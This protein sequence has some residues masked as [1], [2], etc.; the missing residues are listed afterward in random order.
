MSRSGESQTRRRQQ[1]CFKRP[2]LSFVAVTG[3]L[4]WITPQ[5]VSAADAA[6][7]PAYRY[8]RVATAGRPAPGGGTFAAYFEPHVVINKGNDVAF[9][10]DTTDG[11]EGVYLR[12]LGRVLKIAR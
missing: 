5:I 12:T 10:S 11:K 2:A 4:L 3:T 7:G 1:D 9:V 8:V 6:S